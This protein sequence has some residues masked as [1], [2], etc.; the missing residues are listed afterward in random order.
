MRGIQPSRVVISPIFADLP[1]MTRVFVAQGFTDIT[2]FEENDSRSII[3]HFPSERSAVRFVSAFN[4]ATVAGMPTTAYLIDDPK[5]VY[6][7]PLSRPQY[8]EP[9]YERTPYYQHSRVPEDS[10]AY[11]PPPPPTRRV[12][13][14]RGGYPPYP[15]REPPRNYQPPPP[16]IV[17]EPTGYLS[18]RR[19]YLDYPPPPPPP[20]TRDPIHYPSDRRDF[21]DYPPTPPPPPPPVNRD[22]EPVVYPKEI[23]DYPDHPKPPPKQDE[24]EKEVDVAPKPSRMTLSRVIK[25]TGL[26]RYLL[27]PRKIFEEYWETGYI[28][29][30]LIAGENA[31]IQFDTFADAEAAMKQINDNDGRVSNVRASF[32]RDAPL[33]LPPIKIKVDVDMDSRFGPKP[34]FES[35]AF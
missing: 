6:T 24:M 2:S 8:N 21:I 10:R 29:E 23:R 31:L 33:N 34:P 1:G 35:S 22:R 11:S 27:E 4:G 13:P 12:E 19:D 7:P 32:A 9:N 15:E 14:P 30:I 17:R 20:P 25:I 5:P 16:P 28:K 26:P 3:V 18:D